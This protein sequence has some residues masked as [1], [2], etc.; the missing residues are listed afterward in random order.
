MKS[1]IATKKTIYR[2]KVENPHGV[3]G[4]AISV[5]I[6]GKMLSSNRIELVDDGAAH[7]VQVIL[8]DPAVKK[9]AKEVLQET[10]V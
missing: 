8:G 10:A 6:D 2:I 9:A 3:S 5:E 1:S 4:G 7:N